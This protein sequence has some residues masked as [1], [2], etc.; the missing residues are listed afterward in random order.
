[1]KFYINCP[2]WALPYYD[3]KQFD[4]LVMKLKIMGISGFRSNDWQAPRWE[5]KF[6]DPSGDGS[7][8]ELYAEI[9]HQL[10]SDYSLE[11][12]QVV[13]NRNVSVW[14]AL[15]PEERS[16]LESQY[17]DE[18]SRIRA[19]ISFGVGLGIERIREALLSDFEK[20]FQKYPHS[21][22]WQ[23]FNEI[24]GWPG[25]NLYDEKIKE[26]VA[27]VFKAPRL[28]HFE[29]SLNYDSFRQEIAKRVNDPDRV[30]LYGSHHYNHYPYERV[31][32]SNAIGDGDITELGLLGDNDVP[33]KDYAAACAQFWDDVLSAYEKAGKTLRYVCFFEA[34]DPSYPTYEY[35]SHKQVE[36]AWE[37]RRGGYAIMPRDKVAWLLALFVTRYPSNCRWREH[38]D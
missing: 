36:Q 26:P 11:T 19:A 22:I 25:W 14:Q 16:Y 20:L 18:E 32:T 33:E 28:E 13:A 7:E 21:T 3:R 15:T 35:F 27:D 29:I 12:I 23:V 9:G 30:I 34:I 17:R 1:M 4:F 6:L 31:W 37:E 10:A 2:L 5:S 8:W 38:G 24:E